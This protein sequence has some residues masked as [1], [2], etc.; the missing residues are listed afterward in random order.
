MCCNNILSFT[1][2]IE[3][4]KQE[5]IVVRSNTRCVTQ[6]LMIIELLYNKIARPCNYAKKY[7]IDI[8]S[9]IFSFFFFTRRAGQ[10]INEHSFNYFLL[11]KLNLFTHA[12]THMYIYLFLIRWGVLKERNTYPVLWS[13]RRYQLIRNRT[14]FAN[15][16]PFIPNKTKT[17]LL[18][19]M[20]SV[21]S[22]LEI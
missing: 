9:S 13:T 6:N 18:L 4:E 2:I 12:Y 11:K 5:Y 15:Q 1:L 7:Q 8:W 20:H 19:E 16:F 10:S 3:N 14:R 17:S 21:F 22:H